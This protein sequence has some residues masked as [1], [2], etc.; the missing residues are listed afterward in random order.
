MK[1]VSHSFKFA[2]SVCFDRVRPD[3]NDLLCVDRR[4]NSVIVRNE[5]DYTGLY[6]QLRYLC[7]WLCVINTS[8]D[9]LCC[10]TKPAFRHEAIKCCDT[11]CGM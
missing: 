4:L 8:V 11:V 2:N 3:D 6:V 10:C 9:N 7:S 1:S 5:V